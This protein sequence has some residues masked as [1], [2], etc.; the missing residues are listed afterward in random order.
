MIGRRPRYVRCIEV[1]LV[2]VA[3]VAGIGCGE[4]ARSPARV[5]I[6]S[7]TD[8][9]HFVAAAK[10]ITP[11][12]TTCTSLDEYLR[13]GTRGLVA[14]RSKFDVGRSDLCAALRDAPERYARLD[15]LLPGLDSSADAIRVLFARYQKLSPGAVMPDVYFVVGNGIAGGTTT[16]GSA[17]VILVG[18][19]LLH[20]TSGVP[21]TVAHELA[22]TQ[23]HYPLWRS[24]T[25]GPHFFR[26]TL[27][28]QSL[29]EGTADVVAQIL[30]GK[31][32]RSSYGEM[33]EAQLWSQ[34]QRD[35]H[36]RDYAGWLY[37]GGDQHSPDGRPVDLG[38]WIGYRIAKA[39]YDRSADK[40]RAL[41]E[42]LSIQDFDAFLKASG[43]R[44]GA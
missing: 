12:D 8:V 20:S 7:T 32:K 22:H 41:R 18:T 10:R 25:G 42:M 19:E 39:Y 9:H 43:Y 28:R 27:L 44:G 16:H 38:Y 4:S 24:L 13:T 6:V 40:T 26:A 23:Q 31:P 35:M 21:G 36:K 14:Y 29:V 1:T 5:P 37:N 3:A 17:P 34:F 2:A 15:S 30:T 33:H 11:G